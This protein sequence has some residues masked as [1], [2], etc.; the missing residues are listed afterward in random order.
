M[1]PS[2][3]TVGRSSGQ[4]TPAVRRKMQMMAREKRPKE[5]DACRRRTK[6]EGAE[7]GGERQN[8]SVENGRTQSR[9]QQKSKPTPQVR[10]KTV[11]MEKEKRP[12]DA[13][14]C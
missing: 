11:M 3:R 12:K 4:P 10:R 8:C 9:S 7:G 2:S 5:S 6:R 13:D 14:A 1:V